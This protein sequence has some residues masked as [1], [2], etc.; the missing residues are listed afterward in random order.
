MI[1]SVIF[2]LIYGPVAVTVACWLF[3][4]NESARTKKEVVVCI[5]SQKRR[6]SDRRAP[7]PLIVLP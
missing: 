6:R 3:F 4:T 5:V 7:R 2:S 1:N